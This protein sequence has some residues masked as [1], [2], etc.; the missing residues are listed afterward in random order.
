M[1]KIKSTKCKKQSIIIALLI[2]QCLG[3]YIS[4]SAQSSFQAQYGNNAI[5]YV[6][7]VHLLRTE[8]LKVVP[9]QKFDGN[10]FTIS[11]STGTISISDNIS[12]ILQDKSLSAGSN[13]ISTYYGALGTV[14][15]YDDLIKKIRE[16]NPD[17]LKID[18]NK[19]EKP[20]TPA[21]SL[22]I[23]NLV[24]NT[25]LGASGGAGVSLPFEAR[26]INAATELIIDRLQQELALTFFKNFQDNLNQDKMLKML[27]PRTYEYLKVISEKTPLIIP[28]LGA[29]WRGAFEQDIRE[30]PWKF[31]EYYHSRL[32]DT[33][34]YSN[35]MRIF[36]RALETYKMIKSGQHP[37]DII[38]HF[39]LYV[40]EQLQN[41]PNNVSELQHT[42]RLLDHLSQNLLSGSGGWASRESLKLLENKQNRDLFLA[43]LV[44][45]DELQ[46]LTLLPLTVNNE[47]VF[48]T[49]RNKSVYDLFTLI[50]KK[51]KEIRILL[52]EFQQL[53]ASVE[54]SITT[55]RNK[56]DKGLTIP[57]EDYYGYV[58][59]VFD[60]IKFGQKLVYLRDMTSV[61]VND[62][63]KLFDD[64]FVPIGE[65]TGEMMVNIAKNNYGAALGNF[66]GIV[67]KIEDSEI[68]RRELLP[69]ATKTKLIRYASFLMDVINA[70]DVE[71]TKSALQAA[72]LPVGSYSL[73]RN[74]D[75][76]MNV[77]AYPGLNFG[78]EQTKSE[79][80]F[81]YEGKF[82]GVYAPIGIDLTIG[83][84][85]SFS[86]FMGI[87]DLG[88]LVSYRISHTD[89]VQSYPVVDFKQV[90]APSIGFQLGIA[91]TPLTIG[92]TYQIA[93]H[94]RE[95]N[96]NNEAVNRE[97][98]ALRYFF[99]VSVDLNLF[100][101]YTSEKTN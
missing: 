74:S 16:I 40:D 47:S 3:F 14:V 59:T 66:L 19:K 46:N 95:V 30:I 92:G 4:A 9:T 70:K 62:Q 31:A 78:W 81:G 50:L 48:H 45:D 91:G 7:A 94:L 44:K 27:L 89:S 56:Q 96:A 101:L 33:S 63:K 53:T 57:E 17:A 85:W 87:I 28:S 18:E 5:N 26:V 35:C 42:V 51:E 29:A 24:Q 43:I 67:S 39:R 76:S 99:N 36:Y 86:L 10:L 2:A 12:K 60:A 77:S 71:Q 13:P 68:P 69:N 32:S 20:I 64:R 93:P 98:D 49:R 58:R 34:S 22:V 38:H 100:N 84:K 1:N 21:Q 41:N 37:A 23:N 8:I 75:F 79:G 82:V 97:R 54:N 88:T 61:E 25:T 72:A 65:S 83:C 15:S 73:K 6:A 80:A 52:N 11:N 55:I 90:F